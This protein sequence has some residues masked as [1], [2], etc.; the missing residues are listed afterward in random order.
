MSR[1]RIIGPIFFN[2]RTTAQRNRNQILEVF[3]N[4]LHENELQRG[5][6]PQDGAPP[7]VAHQTINYLQEFFGGRL[8]NRDRCPPRSP[9]LTPLDFNLFGSLNQGF[10]K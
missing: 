2:E 7:H 9:D 3:I 10:S 1:R 6:F 4:Q 8:A 5:Y